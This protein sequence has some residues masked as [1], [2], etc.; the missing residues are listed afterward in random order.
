MGPDPADVVVTLANCV[1]HGRASLVELD[2]ALLDY[3]GGFRPQRCQDNPHDFGADADPA[4]NRPKA[5]GERFE[6]HFLTTA[7]ASR[8]ES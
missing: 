1:T 3:L 2:L 5:L 7:A 4:C 8:T 6:N